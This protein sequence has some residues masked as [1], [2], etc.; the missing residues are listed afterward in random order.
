MSPQTKLTY[1]NGAGRAEF[2][3]LIFH[4]GG[5][6]F[7]DK[8]IDYLTFAALKPTLLLGQVPVQEVDGVA[9]SQSMAIARYAAKLASIFPEDPL[10]ALEIDM[11]SES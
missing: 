9:Y 10:K 8:R 6:A 5:I 1:F 3:R 11:I 2:P 7:E 4:F